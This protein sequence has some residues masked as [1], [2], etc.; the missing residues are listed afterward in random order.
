MQE[1]SAF[2]K[3]AKNTGRAFIGLCFIEQLL[4]GFLVV[5]WGLELCWSTCKHLS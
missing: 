1:E 3:T 2:L 4:P 5:L